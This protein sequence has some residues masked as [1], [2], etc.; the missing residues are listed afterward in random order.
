MKGICG[1]KVQCHYFQLCYFIQLCDLKN[2]FYSMPPKFSSCN[3]FPIETQ[4]TVRGSMYT[5]MASLNPGWS[6]SKL[7]FRTR[8]IS[9]SHIAPHEIWC[10]NIQ[11]LNNNNYWICDFFYCK[12]RESISQGKYG[13]GS[14]IFT[15]KRKHILVQS[16]AIELC[17][18]F[19]EISDYNIKSSH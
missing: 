8:I 1:K 12:R 4:V 7:R 3:F 14:I 6:P 16:R 10:L 15:D 5:D 17:Y 13:L 2:Y 11:L 9:C 18:S 19:N